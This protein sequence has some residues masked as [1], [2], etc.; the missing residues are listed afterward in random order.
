MS[1]VADHCE[2]NTSLPLPTKRAACQ[3]ALHTL[4]EQTANG[5]SVQTT[6]VEAKTRVQHQEKVE[7][8]T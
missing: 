2:V 4:A 3:Y 5:Q 8:S 1:S 7:W 6:S